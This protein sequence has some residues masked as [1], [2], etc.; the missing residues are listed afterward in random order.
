MKIR[1]TSI[2]VTRMTE[3]RGKTFRITLNSFAQTR[4]MAPNIRLSMSCADASSSSS[5]SPLPRSSRT[6]KAASRTPASSRYPPA[7]SHFRSGPAADSPRSCSSAGYCGSQSRTPRL[8]AC[9]LRR[10]SALPSNNSTESLVPRPR[11]SIP[12]LPVT[13]PLERGKQLRGLQELSIVREERGNSLL[14]LA[15][16]LRVD[17]VQ[18]LEGLE[19]LQQLARLDEAEPRGLRVKEKMADPLGHDACRGELLLQAFHLALRGHQIGTML[20]ELLLEL[21]LKVH[22]LGAE[23][24]D[25]LLQVELDALEHVLRRPDMRRHRRDLLQI[26]FIREK[27]H[28]SSAP[29]SASLVKAGLPLSTASDHQHLL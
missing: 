21:V 2:L 19:Q 24:G 15:R 6:G 3:S 25:A 1:C 27:K 4:C 14:Q 10:V 17:L 29:Q 23:L 26:A 8:R 22:A 13:N 16:I 28:V 18:P 7:C 12:P 9:R 11:S 20:L 5:R